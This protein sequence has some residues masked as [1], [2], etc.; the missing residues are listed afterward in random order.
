MAKETVESPMPGTIISIKVKVGDM[1][2]EDDDLLVLEAMKMK[3][4]IVAP[5][6]GKV[7][8]IRVAPNQA[9]D[10]GDVMVII[11]H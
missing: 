6:S 9:V 1:V 7:V 11:E 5:L 2:K 3:N 8:E 4:P 10:S